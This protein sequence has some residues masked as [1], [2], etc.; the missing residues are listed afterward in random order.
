MTVEEYQEAVWIPIR[1]AVK[2]LPAFA[3][4]AYNGTYVIYGDGDPQPSHE[5]DGTAVYA[6]VPL[7]WICRTIPSAYAILV[8]R[9]LR[10]E[11][12]PRPEFPPWLK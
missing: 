8:A 9:I 4:Y 7:G 3:G 10:Q 1:E 11:F 5:L 2:R 12:V 6:I